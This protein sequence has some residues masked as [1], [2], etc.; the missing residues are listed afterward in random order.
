MLTLIQPFHLPVPPCEQ[1][2][3]DSGREGGCEHICTND[4]EDA[5]CSCN[6]GFTLEDD[7]KSCKREYSSDNKKGGTMD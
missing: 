4:G 2:V 6:K 5:V 7:K 3:D 1:K